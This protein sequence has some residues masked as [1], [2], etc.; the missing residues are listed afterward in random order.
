MESPLLPV[1][2]GPLEEG[3]ELRGGGGPAQ[4]RAC[5]GHS[6]RHILRACHGP[7]LRAG[8][9]PTAGG[10]ARLRPCSRTRGCHLPVDKI[11]T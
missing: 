4:S 7:V 2:L 9:R 3:G 8:A 10:Q 5:P 1:S 11:E 6:R